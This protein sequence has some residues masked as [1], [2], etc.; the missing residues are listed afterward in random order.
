MNILE[1]YKKEL[2]DAKAHGAS[3]NTI[4]HMSA[5]YLLSVPLNHRAKMTEEDW[6]EWDRLVRGHGKGLIY[7][8]TS[9]IFEEVRNRGESAEADQGSDGPGVDEGPQCPEVDR[10]GA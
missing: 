2:E 8:F 3:N 10:A 5:T 6:K 9:L 1:E 7:H 4:I